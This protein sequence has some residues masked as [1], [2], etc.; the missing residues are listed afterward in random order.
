MTP[1]A[2]VRPPPAQT[3][4]TGVTLFSLL[5]SLVKNLPTSNITATPSMALSG[6][7]S[8]SE[9]QNKKNRAKAITD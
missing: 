2:R 8:S 9:T 5:A 6:D 3:L 7:I 1:F 4:I